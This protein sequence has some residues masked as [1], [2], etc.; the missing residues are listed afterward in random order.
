MTATTTNTVTRNLL[1]F[2]YTCENADQCT[3]E[4]A[5]T[6][7]WIKNGIHEPTDHAAETQR[8]LQNYYN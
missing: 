1:Q 7:C 6:E 3:T 5:C 8:L 2:C 4:K